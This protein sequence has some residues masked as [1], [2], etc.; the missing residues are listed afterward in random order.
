MLAIYVNVTGK[1]TNLVWGCIVLE[2]SLMPILSPVPPQFGS[3]PVRVWEQTSTFIRTLR[4]VAFSG[5]RNENAPLSELVGSIPCCC[6][7]RFNFPAH[8]KDHE[9]NN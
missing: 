5:L 7:S 6:P 4:S 2:D 9:K 1:L 3:L 8:C